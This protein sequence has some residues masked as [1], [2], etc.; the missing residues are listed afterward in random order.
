MERKR[1]K[2]MKKT[3]GI[4][5]FK[6]KKCTLKRIKIKGKQSEEE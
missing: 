4:F 1:K 5:K 3:H 2:W 6:G